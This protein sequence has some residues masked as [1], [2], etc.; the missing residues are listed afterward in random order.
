MAVPKILWF[1]FQHKYLPQPNII[2]PCALL[3]LLI[4]S[5]FYNNHTVGKKLG[6]ILELVSL[7]ENK[8]I[9]FLQ[10]TYVDHPHSYLLEDV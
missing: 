6:S 2:N 1:E 7:T 10:L 3:E 5:V 9:D 8:T 4:T